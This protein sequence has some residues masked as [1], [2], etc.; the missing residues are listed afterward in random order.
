[1][2]FFYGNSDHLHEHIHIVKYFTDA[3]RLQVFIHIVFKAYSPVDIII[4]KV[5]NLSLRLPQA[6]SLQE[7]LYYCTTQ[8]VYC[9][10]STTSGMLLVL[11]LSSYLCLIAS[12]LI[13]INPCTG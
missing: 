2:H 3:L 4:H 5:C 7:V 6:G 13:E 8:I 12:C 11:A 1:M 9:P 10:R